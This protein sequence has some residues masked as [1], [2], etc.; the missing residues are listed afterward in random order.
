MAQST[1]ANCRAIPSI[2]PSTISSDLDAPPSFDPSDTNREV[3]IDTSSSVDYTGYE[4]IDWN[5][6]SGYCIRK[7]RRRPRT[8]WVW[9]HGF[10]IEKDGSGRRFWLCKD[11]HGKKATI[12]HMYDAA[13]TSQANGHMEDVHRINRD[14]P[15]SPQRK[16]QHTLFD[17]ADLDC[18]R[19]KDQAVMNAFIASFDPVRFQHLLVRWVACDNVP[20]NKLE[21][22]YFRE[23]MGYANSAI[24]ESGSLPTHTTIRDWIVRS[25]NRHKGVVTEILGRSL[26]RINISFDAWSSRKFTSLLGLAV[27]FL[28]DEG[29][30][31][32]FLL[33]LPQIEGRHSGENLADR[34]SEII[35]EYGFEDR[36]GYFVADNAE[37]ND[38]CL[39]DLGTEFGFNKQHRR[40]RCCGHIINL[41]ARSILFGTD[42]D[43]FED[44]CQAEKEIHDEI[45]LW[46]SKGP[47]GKLHNIIHWVQRSG[48]RI[49]KL[50]KLQLIENT[51]LNLEDKTTYNVVTDNATRWN[52]SEAMMERGYQ[53]RNALDSLVQAEVTEW[54]NY[55]AR[56]TQNGTKPMPKK[57]RTKPAIVDDKMSVEDWSV[58]TE[59][60]AI[61][62]PLKIATKRLEGRPKEGKFGA[63]WEVLLTM[64]WLLKH[65]EEFKVQHELDEEPH[66]RIGCNLGWRKLD[67]YY[68]LTEDSPVYLAALI[69]HPAF[70][71]STVESQWVDHPDWL[72]RGKAAVQELWE[73][74]RNLPVE[75]ETIPEQPTV[76]R[77][78]TDL[79]DFMASIRKLSTRPARLPSATRDEYAEWV[80]TTDPGD[81]LV[82]NPIQYWLLRRRQYPRLSRMAID[83]F[84]IP[85]MS[86]EPERIFSLA[87]Q[88]VTAQRGRLQADIIGAAQYPN[89]SKSNQIKSNPTFSYPNQIKLGVGF[90]LIYLFASLEWAD[91]LASKGL[92]QHSQ[93]GD[94]ENLYMGTTDSPYSAA[95]KAFLAEGSQYNGEAISGSNYMSFGHYTQ[96]IWKYTTKVG[97]GVSKDS[98]GTSWVVARYQKPGNIIGEKPY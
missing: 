1:N 4:G 70:R 80:A 25:F 44:D 60:L 26:G 11:C 81:C 43:A 33:G 48:Q 2:T 9:E 19:P 88:M 89:R 97:M 49:E 47:L 66:L 91:H 55:V 30:F 79:D 18:R 38:T 36:I 17:M 57:S 78:T 13:S 68:T 67:R 65:L 69:L 73:E 53:L 72:V 96:C 21:S 34:V 83:V 22:P 94:G 64:E 90:D 59:Y 86:T 61:L 15:M 74:Y 87:G 5:R 58:I 95:V 12:T 85:A 45:K 3:T 46:R 37:S 71:W 75:Q 7:Q 10:D 56:R 35:H 29:K 8:G 39:E 51:A 23:L 24:I 42:A 92:L 52:S 54:N 50:H 32:T 16:K 82:D 31:R 41:V 84:S 93:G 76:P 27:H 40:L 77:K 62:K 98:S 6:L 20:F 28:D 63:I 14:G